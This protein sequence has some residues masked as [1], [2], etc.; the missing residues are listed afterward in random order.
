MIEMAIEF[1]IHVQF[2]FS[3]HSAKGLQ[4]DF[5]AGMRPK[6]PSFIALLEQT[7]QKKDVRCLCT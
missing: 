7:E 1:S 6:F 4:D 3:D 5:Y 2:A